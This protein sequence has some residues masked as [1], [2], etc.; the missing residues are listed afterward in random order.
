M[1][2]DLFYEAFFF[3]TRHEAETLRLVCRSFDTLCT[4]LRNVHGYKL[5]IDWMS[6]GRSKTSEAAEYSAIVEVYGGFHQIEGSEEELA[7][8]LKTL[9]TSSFVLR[10][11]IY[12]SVLCESLCGEYAAVFAG[13]SAESVDLVRQ[14]E[15]MYYRTITSSK[16]WA[17]PGP[18]ASNQGPGRA[19][20]RRR[21]RPGLDPR[22]GRASSL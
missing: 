2:P 12:T 13:V 8:G 10:G 4:G 6:I 9:L 1:S 17:R 3:F 7:A 22:T 19:L 14:G 16:L 15:P 11:C 18:R 5:Q 21:T 20:T